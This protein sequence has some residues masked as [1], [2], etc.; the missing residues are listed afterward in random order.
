MTGTTADLIEVTRING[1]VVSVRTFDV[2]ESA[3]PNLDQIA[4]TINNK[5]PGGNKSQAENVIFWGKDRVQAEVAGSRFAD[6]KNVYS[7]DPDAALD[8]EYPRDNTYGGGLSNAS[9]YAL[10]TQVMNAL[11][12][13]PPLPEDSGGSAGEGGGCAKSCDEAPGE[14]DPAGGG[15]EDVGGW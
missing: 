7:M 3:N 14:D 6:N 2:T 8:A 9:D 1:K 10:H 12:P 5:L 11:M 4:S 15:V 13:P